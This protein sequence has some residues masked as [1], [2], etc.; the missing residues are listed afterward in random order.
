M[1]NSLS[2][3]SD[4]LT[5]YAA[6]A[7]ETSPS[8]I[9]G[10]NAWMENDDLVIEVSVPGYDKGKISVIR[11]GDKLSIVAEKDDVDTKGREYLVRSFETNKKFEKALFIPEGMDQEKAEAEYDSGILKVRIPKAEKSKKKI[12]DIK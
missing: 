7:R 5:N 4:L 11:E 12:L 10:V 2:T 3:L 1:L 6:C 8:Y 9:R